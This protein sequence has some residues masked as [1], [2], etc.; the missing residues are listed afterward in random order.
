[1]SEF[2]QTQ[3]DA[4]TAAISQGVTRVEY[5]GKTVTY[6]S[7]PEMLRLRDRMIRDV[8]ARGDGIRPPVAR[9]SVFI[10]R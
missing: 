8:A 2:T 3:L 7:I 6:G 1:M 10:R 4:L 5:D 9:P